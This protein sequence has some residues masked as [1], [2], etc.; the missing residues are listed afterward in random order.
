M[1]ISPLHHKTRKQ[2]SVCVDVMVFFDDYQP[3]ILVYIALCLAR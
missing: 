2:E 3:S 1:G